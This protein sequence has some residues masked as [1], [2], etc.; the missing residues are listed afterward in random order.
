MDKRSVAA[1][2]YVGTQRAVRL[3][4]LGIK[5]VGDLLWYFPRRYEDRRLLKG[6]ATLVPGEK[7]TVR[8][9]I[10]GWEEREV[11]PN[12][13]LLR[14]LVEDGEGRGYALW[15]NQ[16]FVRRRLKLGGE[17]FLTGKVNY[18]NFLPEIQVTDYE[19]A[20]SGEDGLHAGRIVPFYPL[21][22][23]LS[24]RWLRLIVH[25][26]LKET[27]GKIP[28]ILPPSLCTRYRLI[29]RCRALEYIHFPPD[30]AALHQ[31]RRRLKYEE[32][33]IWELALVL[34]RR[35]REDGR[36]GIAHTRDNEM[37]RRFIAALP[38]NLTGAQ[39]RVLG[40]ILA[41]MEKPR[42]MARLL[43]G[44]VG[45]G[46]T[47]VAAAAMVKAVGGG[48]QAALMAPTEVLAEQHGRTL[49]RLL[50]PLG[51]PVAVLTGN[52]PRAEREAIL[53]GLITGRLPLVVGTHT[54]IQENVDFKALGLVVID[55]QHRFGVGQ[56]AALQAKG[57]APDLLVMTATPIPRTLALAIY[58]DLEISLL[59]EMP[60]G[61]QPVTTYVLTEKQR[62]KAYQL[63]RKEIARGH[64]AYVICPLI[65]E[66][67]GIAA[68]AATAMYQK[69]KEEVFPEYKI[70]LLHGRL[71]PSVKEE[72]MESFRRGD[73][74][75]LVATT[76]VEVGVDVPN[77]TVML[78]EGAER[79]GLAQL[80]QLRG[81]V[82]RGQDAS[83]CLLMAGND[84]A[85][86]ER[87]KILVTNSDGFAIAEA[88]LRLRGPGEFFGTRQHG[89][90]E[91]R[92]ASLP[93]DLRIL[94]HAREDAHRI[95]RENL[96]Q[97]PEYYGLYLAA[98][99][100]LDELKL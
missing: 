20:G 70:G 32:L 64:Q 89:L 28:E 73:L 78:I 82:G 65:D 56:R 74:A 27:A 3:K 79:L 36:P 76:V 84:G 61:R 19:V 31:A 87:L 75:V 44:D 24:Q 9:M 94:E 92:L 97:Q 49:H 26:A 100:K 85:A 46:K 37:V 50:A 59:D 90:P 58:G 93:D 96:W 69:L 62:A 4:K 80:H 22:G 11:R 68:E 10:K 67:E 30:P 95:C 53:S 5:T 41:D 48:W 43:Q 88:D 29:P 17:V 39:E 14:A 66:S 83:Y 21:T 51:I 34:S 2:K 12:L 60:P 72:V 42:P 40:E 98:K 86:R 71:K 91:F 7:A 99:E 35:E 18:H 54:L 81:R 45:S 33:L 77:A 16:P 55:E 63:I 25:Q 8:V 57:D 13:R 38:F 47:V 15:F 52:T 1:L 6:L 23:G